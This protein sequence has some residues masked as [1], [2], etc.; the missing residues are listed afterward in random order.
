MISRAEQG[1]ETTSINDAEPERRRI[2]L[3]HV[4]S[5]RRGDRCRVIT[6]TTDQHSAVCFDMPVQA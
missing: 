5:T 4:K 6:F 2:P 3:V 1:Y